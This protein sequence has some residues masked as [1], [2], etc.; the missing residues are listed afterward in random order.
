MLVATILGGILADSLALLADAGHLLSDVGAL[1]IALLAARLATRA[2]TATRTFGLQRSEVLGALFNG[3]TLVV[4]SALI[5]V[6]AVSRLSDPP[7]VGGVGVLALG[8]VGL[9]GNLA[10]SIVL[11]GGER[12]D[13]NLEGALRHSVGDALSSLGVIV[14]GVVVLATG[15]NTIDPL[16]SLLIAGLIAAGSWRLLKEPIDVLLE[17]APPG[18]DVREVGR[19]ICAQPGVVEVHDLHVWTV[20]SGFTA[21]AAHVVVEPGADRDLARR[22]IEAVLDERFDIH[23]TTLQMVESVEE[24]RLIQVERPK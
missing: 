22:R 9:L 16:V 15:W 12:E 20:T 19:A 23:H 5:V 8:A 14:A 6:G 13:I 1:A 11:L 4:I 21:L 10:A 7:D 18:T 2:P 17:A 24:P 3:I